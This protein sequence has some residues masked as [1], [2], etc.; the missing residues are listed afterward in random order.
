MTSATVIGAE[1]CCVGSDASARGALR[2]RPPAVCRIRERSARSRESFGRYVRERADARGFGE[3]IRRMT[4]APGG[5]LRL[6]GPRPHRGRGP[7]PISC[8]FDP[9]T[10]VDTATYVA[11]YAYPRGRRR[12]LRERPASVA[13]RGR[14]DGRVARPSAPRRPVNLSELA[15]DDRARIL[16][17]GP[18]P[19]ASRAAISC[20]PPGA[21]ADGVY[22]IVEGPRE[23]RTHARERLGVD[24]RH[25]QSRRR[26]S[27]RSARRSE[28]ALRTTSAVALE[29]GSLSRIDVTVFLEMLGPRRRARVGFRARP[30]ATASRRAER[31]LVELAGKSVPG[32]AR[33]RP[34]ARSRPITANPIPAAACASPYI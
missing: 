16:A 29:D 13:R 34:S 7:T 28:T 31:E 10:I 9:K 30:R 1:F 17:P 23:D 14:A 5:S 12:R 27:A 4:L 24:R 20:T 18:H 19:R 6:E 11:P 22:F 3:A 33:R 8:S 25:P 15:P 2:V 21:A 26:P 32:P